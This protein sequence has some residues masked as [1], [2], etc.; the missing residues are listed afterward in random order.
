[1]ELEEKIVEILA[2]NRHHPVYFPKNETY[3]GHNING[4]EHELQVSENETQRE[5]L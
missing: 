2:K 3:S 4:K 5:T 1:V